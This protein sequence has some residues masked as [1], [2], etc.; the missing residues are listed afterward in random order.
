LIVVFGLLFSLL[1]CT[2][3]SDRPVAAENG[4]LAGNTLD[5]VEEE[6][7]RNVVEDYFVRNSAVPEYEVTI[8]AV[9]QDWARVS[10][11]P[12]GVETPDENLVYLQNQ[13]TAAVEV[14]TA[15]ATPLSGQI[16][17]ADTTSGWTIIIGP[18]VTFTEAELNTAA[19][20]QFIRQ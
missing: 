9:E 12:V 15:D 16:A 10:I 1:G 2:S 18:Q 13:A 7:I 8:L 3:S 6:Q 5:P 14:P 20:P 19:V 4:L 11:A 17:P